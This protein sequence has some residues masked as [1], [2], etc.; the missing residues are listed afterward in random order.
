VTVEIDDR[1]PAFLGRILDDEGDPIGTCFQVKPGVLVTAWHV[2]NDLDRGEVGAGVRLDPLQG[3]PPRDARVER[4]DL[5]H[6]LAVVVTDK[7]LADCVAGWTGT[8]AVPQATPVTVTGVVIMDDPGHSYRYL[9]SSGHWAG[10]TTR[11]DGIRLGRMVAEALM[12]GMSGAPVLSGHFLVGVVSARYNSADGWARNSVWVIRTEDLAPLLAGLNGVSALKVDS[13]QAAVIQAASAQIEKASAAGARESPAM[14]GDGV[15][16]VG[17]D[18]KP[19]V[20]RTAGPVS[21]GNGYYALLSSTNTNDIIANNN[22]AGPATIT[23]GADVR[24][25]NVSGCQP[26]FWQ[27]TDV[28]AAIDAARNL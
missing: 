16:V 24:A 13:A 7:P 8:D 17:L 3:G 5:S 22:I 23:V 1:V 28:D 20:Y 14:G 26:W 27:G 15:F 21:G 12:K 11:D 25:V 9:D 18:I 19:G 2:L 6:D 4:I 10:G